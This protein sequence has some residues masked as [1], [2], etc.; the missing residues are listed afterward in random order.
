MWRQF[1]NSWRQL[2]L[3]CCGCSSPELL[4][5]LRCFSLFPYIFLPCSAHVYTYMHN[6]I[7]V[8]SLTSIVL[9]LPEQLCSRFLPSQVASVVRLDDP[10]SLVLCEG[11]REREGRTRTKGKVRIIKKKR[12]FITTKSSVL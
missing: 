1:S 12:E 5:L 9:S 6:N 11:C 10:G 7:I 4:N 2:R 3:H 8:S